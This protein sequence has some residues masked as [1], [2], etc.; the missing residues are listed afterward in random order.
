MK[1]NTFSITVA[2]L[3]LLSLTALNATPVTTEESSPGANSII[4]F[5]QKIQDTYREDHE[6]SLGEQRGPAS[7]E[8]DPAINNGSGNSL[9]DEIGLSPNEL[10]FMSVDDK[11]Q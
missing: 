8:N 2:L 4:L 7:L 11:P 5:N 6:Q 1:T 3:N 10:E 9:A